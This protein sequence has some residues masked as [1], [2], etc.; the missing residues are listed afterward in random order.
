MI[1]AEQGAE[2]ANA[3]HAPLD[4][5]FVE[6][7]AKDVDA[8]GTGEIVESIAVQVGYRHAICRLQESADRQIRAHHAAVLERHPVGAGELQIGNVFAG[9]RRVPA[10][11]GKARLVERGKLLESSAPARR[12]VIRRPVGAKELTLI[13]FV[14]RNEGREAARNARMAGNGAVLCLRQFEA[15]AHGGQRGGN[16]RRAGAVECQR[17]RA[18]SHGQCHRIGV[19]PE[20]LTLP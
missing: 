13:V 3:R 9:L 16:R 7:V 2:V 10:R 12:D 11:F 1:R 15:A 17:D 8:V 5:V 4:G 6:V 20:H 14:E 18:P 19:Y